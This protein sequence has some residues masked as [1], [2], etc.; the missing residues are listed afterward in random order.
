[1]LLISASASA[2]NEATVIDM[3]KTSS[4]GAAPSRSSHC[5]IRPLCTRD[6]A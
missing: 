3:M 2:S 5:A 1:M 4:P 6:Q